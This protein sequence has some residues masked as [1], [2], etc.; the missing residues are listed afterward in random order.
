LRAERDQP[1]PAVR[2]VK[3]V[4]AVLLG[5]SAK[6]APSDHQYPGFS[7]ESSLG[8]VSV[9][10][11]GAATLTPTETFTKHLG[12]G[13]ALEDFNYELIA[14][15]PPSP[16]PDLGIAHEAEFPGVCPRFG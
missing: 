10:S 7:L 12:D 14:P 8:D 3:Y 6:L 15:G 2:H 1:A 4:R 5:S 11:D 13:I 16:K 9:S